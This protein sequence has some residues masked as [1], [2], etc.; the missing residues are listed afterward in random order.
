M[1]CWLSDSRVRF[2]W[3][4]PCYGNV[5]CGSVLFGKSIVIAVNC[6]VPLREVKYRYSKSIVAFCKYRIGLVKS[7][8]AM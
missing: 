6:T 8:K 7:S 5:G 1:T 4:K 3:V 2:R